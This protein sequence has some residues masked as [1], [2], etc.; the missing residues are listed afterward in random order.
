[1]KYINLTTTTKTH[2]DRHCSL[3]STDLFS[4]SISFLNQFSS[5]WIQGTIRP[6]LASALNTDLHSYNFFYGGKYNKWLR[7]SMCLFRQS[8][9]L[10][11]HNFQ[12]VQKTKEKQQNSQAPLSLMPAPWAPYVPEMSSDIALWPLS[13]QICQ[14]Y[15]IIRHGSLTCVR[16]NL[17]G[18]HNDQARLFD[19]CE[20]KS[21][22]CT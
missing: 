8:K 19:L 16:S 11:Q 20:V 1:M 9:V 4:S 5:Q 18:V 3:L 21:G 15:I 7:H 2:L 13:D 10:K 6:C 17:A 22:R 14:V 12:A